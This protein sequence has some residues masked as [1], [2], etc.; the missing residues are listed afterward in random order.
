VSVAF[1]LMYV[2]I[3]LYYVLSLHFAVSELGH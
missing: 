2:A 3:L 1:E